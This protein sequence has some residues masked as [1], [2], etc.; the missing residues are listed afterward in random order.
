VASSIP[1]ATTGINQNN[2]FDRL[3]P[4]HKNKTKTNW[5]INKE[6]KRTCSRDSEVLEVHQRRGEEKGAALHANFQ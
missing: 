5:I 1:T 4:S 3:T 6:L 2:P